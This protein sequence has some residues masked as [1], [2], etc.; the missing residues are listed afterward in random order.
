MDLK[1]IDTI[2]AALQTEYESAKKVTENNIDR[3]YKTFN[4]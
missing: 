4:A 2:H 1:K 3:S